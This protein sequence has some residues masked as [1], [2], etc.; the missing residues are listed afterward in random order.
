M[1]KLFS[2]ISILIFFL[3]TSNVD[4]AV[5]GAS[6][7]TAECRELIDSLKGLKRAQ[8]AVSSTLV[9]NHDLMSETLKSYSEALSDSKGKAYQS[10]AN[11]MNKISESF[12]TRGSKSKV[13]SEAISDNTQVLIYLAEKCI[14][15]K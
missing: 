3:A 10:I 5:S 1:N 4:A 11:N 2:L 8:E 13:L 12:K 9:K 15:V 6:G 14:S 7:P